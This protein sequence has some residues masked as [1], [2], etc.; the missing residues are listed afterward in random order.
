MYKRR[1]QN[2]F[3]AAAPKK[4]SD[5][6]GTR[7]TGGRERDENHYEGKGFAIELYSLREE[8]NGRR[9][10]NEGKE[11]TASE[12]KERRNGIVVTTVARGTGVPLRAIGAFSRLG[13]SGLI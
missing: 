13:A 8:T 5:G 3:P 9:S 10:R 11:F 12:E 6:V 7:G 1:D 2:S 4:F